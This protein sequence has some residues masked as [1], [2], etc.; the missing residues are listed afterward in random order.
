MCKKPEA[1]EKWSYRRMLGISWMD[2]VHNV[3]VPTRMSKVSE[4]MLTIT[5]EIWNTLA[6]ISETINTL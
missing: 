4:V 3:D 6:T 1:F 2:K 5:N